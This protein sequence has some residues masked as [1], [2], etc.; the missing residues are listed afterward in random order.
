MAKRIPDGV[1]PTMITPFT[2]DGSRIDWRTLE[3]K[4]S[5]IRGKK[6]D[7]TNTNLDTTKQEARRHVTHDA[8]FV[9]K[10]TLINK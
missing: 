2:N 1:W 3:G 5:C 10:A 6:E 4:S 7:V 9:I 8:V